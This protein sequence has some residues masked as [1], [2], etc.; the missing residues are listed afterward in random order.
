MDILTDLC[1]LNVVTRICY[2]VDKKLRCNY[3][4]NSRVTNFRYG[5]EQFLCQILLLHTRCC[6]FELTF[7]VKSVAHSK[8]SSAS[9]RFLQELGR[10]NYVTATSYLELIGS[11]QELLTK[12]RQ[13]IMEAKQRYV[14]GLDQLAFAESQVNFTNCSTCSF[15]LRNRSTA[16]ATDAADCLTCRGCVFP[17]HSLSNSA[18]QLRKGTPS[19]SS[20]YRSVQ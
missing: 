6:C 4:Y 13:A 1:F 5:T 12:K 10:H 2:L 14:N 9:C 8:L 19:W 17:V 16:R 18:R 15:A 11:F 3:G 7:F 20:F